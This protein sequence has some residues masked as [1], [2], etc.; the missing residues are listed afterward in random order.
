MAYEDDQNF[1]QDCKTR[2]EERYGF[3]W[4]IKG[5]L[6]PG[7]STLIKLTLTKELMRAA[8]YDFEKLDIWNWC[9]F[10]GIRPTVTVGRFPS[11]GTFQDFSEPFLFRTG[12]HLQTWPRRDTRIYGRGR[13]RFIKASP[14][15]KTETL[16]TPEV[17]QSL[18][19]GINLLC[20]PGYI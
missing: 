9:K 8:L 19:S 2:L 18:A 10:L 11:P 13:D 7:K 16:A 4:I 15:W 1:Q 14:S 3:I 5:T 12:E 17:T 6:G 20:F